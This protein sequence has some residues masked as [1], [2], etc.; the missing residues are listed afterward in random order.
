MAN[1]NIDSRRNAERIDSL[2]R[3]ISSL[4]EQ[5]DDLRHEW[6][7]INA[8]S[9]D[10]STVCPHCGQPLPEHMVQEAESV[11]KKHKADL[12]KMNND[13]GHSLAEQRRNFAAELA[14][15]EKAAEEMETALRQ[16]EK[17]LKVLYDNLNAH[18]TA[19][20]AEV[21]PQEIAQWQTLQADIDKLQ[22]ALDA[23]GNG[24]DADKDNG[25]ADLIARLTD[26]RLLHLQ[27]ADSIKSRLAKRA[28]IAQAEEEIAR[29]KE[30]GKALAQQIADLEKREYVAAEFSKKKIEDCEERINGMFET[31]RFKM[32]DQTQDGNEFETCVPYVKGVPFPTCNTAGQLNAGL[33]I[34]RT[35]CRFNNICAPIFID[36]A[37]SVNTFLKVQS[38]II[39]LQV[40]DDKEL[41]IK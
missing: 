32:F 2:K 24:A 15:K 22:K 21:K 14:D 11:W 36:Q 27:E 9:Y 3:N 26:S 12:L 35:L 23:L 41:V 25:D 19:T 5:L 10:G 6:H 33:D 17:E 29:L 34:I 8:S 20:V 28:Q 13:R 39:F 40:T 38:Q 1:L 16:K 18:P 30:H 37:E 4:D 7:E 31:V